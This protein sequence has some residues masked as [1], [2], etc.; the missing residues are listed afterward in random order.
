MT[1]T[2]QSKTAAHLHE[3]ACNHAPL[4]VH[5]STTSQRKSAPSC[6][7]TRILAP[8]QHTPRA[9]STPNRACRFW[10]KNDMLIGIV[11]E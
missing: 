9:H 11:N 8:I 7:A 10:D 6:S 1:R 3:S 4:G 5:S 2:R